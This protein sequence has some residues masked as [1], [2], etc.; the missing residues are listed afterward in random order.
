VRASGLLPE[1]AGIGLDA[2]MASDLVDALDKLELPEGCV[3]AV[4]QGYRLMS[5]IIG[6]A[7]TVK[8]KGAVHSGSRLM[9]WCVGNAKEEKGRQS[10]MINKYAA[11]SAKIDPLMAAFNATKLLETNPEAVNNNGGIAGWLDSLKQSKAVA[12]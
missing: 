10:V 9:A 8:F 6:L 11:G 1:K 7:R 12:A 4:G 5:A 2:A 3:V